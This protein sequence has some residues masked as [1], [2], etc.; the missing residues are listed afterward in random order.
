MTL[1]NRSYNKTTVHCRCRNRVN[2][3]QTMIRITYTL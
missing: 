2:I 1:Y 3:L